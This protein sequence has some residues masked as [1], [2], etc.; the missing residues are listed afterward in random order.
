MAIIEVKTVVAGPTSGTMLEIPVAEGETVGEGGVRTYAD[1]TAYASAARQALMSCTSMDFGT[2][3][4]GRN[5]RTA[6]SG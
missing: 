4:C 6:A 2:G 1:V 5:S 3:R